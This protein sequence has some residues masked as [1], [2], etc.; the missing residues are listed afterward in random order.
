ML[1]FYTNVFRT[2]YVTATPKRSDWREDRIYQISIKNIPFIDLF[3]ENNDPHTDYI[4]IKWNSRPTQ[5]QISMCR[6]MY[7]L[8]RNKYIDYLTNQPVYEKL[9]RIILDLALKNKGKCLI[10]IGTNKAIAYTAKWIKCHYP[11]LYNDVGVF[12]TLVPKEEKEFQ[13][14]KKIILSTTKSA[15]AALDIADLK[16]TVVLD[17]PF[18]SHVLAQQT[19][20]RTRADETSYTECIDIGFSQ[21]K[22]Y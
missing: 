10:Y 21:I 6:N 20:G 12:T 1:D 18:K 16:M 15:G 4:A 14:D 3:D 11:E 22:R 9:L 7:G 2:Y 19:L 8:D 13:K 5:Q 17:E